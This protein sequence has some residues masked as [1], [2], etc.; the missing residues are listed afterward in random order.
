MTDIA[1]SMII[2]LK[3]GD[4]SESLEK[5]ISILDMETEL[6]KAFHQAGKT[7]AQISDAS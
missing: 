5:R 3:V 4:V 6:T 2:K 1:V 7:S